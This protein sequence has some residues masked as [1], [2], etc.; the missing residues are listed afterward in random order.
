MQVIIEAIAV[1][2]ASILSL[3]N[4]IRRNARQC[5]MFYR[6]LAHFWAEH[7][8]VCAAVPYVLPYVGACVSV[9]VR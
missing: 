7:T 4:N 9:R 8:A 3:G 5:R 2:F 1:L 6:R